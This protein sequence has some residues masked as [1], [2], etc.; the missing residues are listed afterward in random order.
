[1]PDLLLVVGARPRDSRL[2]PALRRPGGRRGS[3][4]QAETM[5][6][7]GGGADPGDPGPR[8]RALAWGDG[9]RAGRGAA[10]PELHVGAGGRRHRDPGPVP[11]SPAR[12]ELLGDLV[13]AVRRRAARAA[14][15]GR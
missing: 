4:G 10:G 11:G 14:A 12:R 2:I 7:A 13:P 6:L 1:V 15:P 5:V 9:R 8:P 3:G